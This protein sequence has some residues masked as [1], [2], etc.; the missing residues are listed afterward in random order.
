MSSHPGTSESTKATVDNHLQAFFRKSVDGVVQDYAKDSILITSDGP[1]RGL[2]E[3]RNF[4]KTFI[5]TMPAGFLEAFKM[6]RQE[7]VGEIGYI[8]WDVSPWVH[9]ATDTFVVRDGKIVMQTFA[10]HPP[11]W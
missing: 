11:S 4:F 6:Q 2:S 10:A 3:I 8:V 7:F 5:E 9:F 1:I